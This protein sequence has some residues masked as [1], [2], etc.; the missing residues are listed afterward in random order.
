MK[1]SEL[2]WG[3]DYLVNR[4]RNWHD[5]DYVGAGYGQ[6]Q[7]V[8]LHTTEVATWMWNGRNSFERTY[9]GS[10]RGT[11]GVLA[12]VLDP[13]TGER[14][15]DRLTIVSLASI[16]GEWEILWPQVQEAARK[17]REERQAARDARYALADRT[18]RAVPRVLAELGM[19]SGVAVYGHDRAL[20][21]VDV[22][23]IIADALEI[24]RSDREVS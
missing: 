2:K 11:Y 12:Y 18:R 8:R 19:T 9:K 23:E 21:H 15:G 5:S 6:T 16:R 17:A 1:A 14:A 22:L 10:S 4:T 3:T 13:A 7:R 24:A 20:V